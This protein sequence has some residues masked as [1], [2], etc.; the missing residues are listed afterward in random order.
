MVALKSLMQ[1]EV[2]EEIYNDENGDEYIRYC[3]EIE[4][5]RICFDT[6]TEAEEF[7]EE[8]SP[9]GPRL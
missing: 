6:N 4:G 2:K 9:R 5:T 8:N 1:M 7:I 3:V